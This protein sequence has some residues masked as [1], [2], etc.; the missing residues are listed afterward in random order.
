MQ[1]ETTLQN[2]NTR[3]TQHNIT[4]PDLQDDRKMILRTN[5]DCSQVQW[6][7]RL[8]Q[9]LI[10][11]ALHAERLVEL[12]CDRAQCAICRLVRRTAGHVNPDS[13]VEAVRVV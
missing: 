13:A 10:Y 6:I 4:R 5:E 9:E 11:R 3:K 2:K 1:K 8:R 12:A 7:H